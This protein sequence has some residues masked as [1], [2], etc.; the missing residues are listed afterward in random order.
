MTLLSAKIQGDQI[1]L[2]F[3]EMKTIEEIEA[4]KGYEVNIPKDEAPLEK[5][6]YR[7]SDLVGCRILDQAGE[8]LG[9]V[10]EVFAY[11]P[12]WTLR[13]SRPE[14]KD[15]FV[16]FVDAFVK[17]INIEEKTIRIEVVEGLL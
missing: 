9:K 6:E 2:G 7:Y 4:F 3:E 14:K 12:T 8:E 17:E 1:L 11:S 5:D 15:F 13:V 16:P 10:K